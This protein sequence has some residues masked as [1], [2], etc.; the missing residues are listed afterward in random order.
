M[1]WKIV[2]IGGLVYYVVVFISSMITGMII[3]EGL[4]EAAYEATDAFWRPALRA[5]PPD[6]AAMLPMWLFNGLVGSLV[7]AAIYSW[8]RPVFAG[9]GWKKGLTYGLMLGLL[10]ATIFL[11]M[12]G[13]FDL[14][15]EIWLWWS[16]DTAILFLIGG[17]VL[18]IVADRVAPVPA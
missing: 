16:I 11:G 2:V 5:D 4:L 18:G 10:A 15:G 13:V 9:P 7:V 1:N 12:S 14:P 8:I 6:V 17:T 3:H